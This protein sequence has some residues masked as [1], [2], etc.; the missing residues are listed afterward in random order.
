[1]DVGV[2]RSVAATGP[3]ES[4]AVGVVDGTLDLGGKMVPAAGGW[5]AFVARFAK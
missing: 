4:I 2:V 5:D 3:G 1:M